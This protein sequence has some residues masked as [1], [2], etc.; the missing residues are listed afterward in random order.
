MLSLRKL[1][2]LSIFATL[3]LSTPISA[4]PPEKPFAV[5]VKA[6][7]VRF[8]AISDELTAVGTL[9]A[10][11]SVIIRPEIAG[12]IATIHFTEGQTVSKGARLFTI[13]PAE[14]E[15]RLADSSAQMKLAQQRHD[16]ALELVKK[17]FI[18]EQALDE[19]NETLAQA[20]AR[21]TQ[22]KVQIAKT[23]LRAP[24]A[25]VLGL[26]QV[27]PGAYVQPGQDL[28]K[29][30]NIGTI[31]L[32]F[33][34]PETYVPKLRKHQPVN[35]EVDAYPKRKFVGEIYAMESGIDVATRTAMLRARIPN[36][37]AEL[38][39]GMFARVII[40]LEKRDHALLIPEQATIPQGNSVSVYRIIDG[41]AILTQVETG[42]RSKG[43]IEIV[44]GL[45]DK[46]IVITD[47]QMKLHNGAPV[48][49]MGAAPIATAP[50]KKP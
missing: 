5:P 4:A 47:G 9:V 23:E 36:P 43:E 16:R 37:N 12:R 8:G 14:Y 45:N 10:N 32:D 24:F 27:S 35:I 49:V 13:E 7:P 26:R 11:E 38:I 34:I 21:Y 2:A 31:K 3:L 17:H 1:I 15:A 39:S 29:L 20:I 41:K 42:Q 28:V 30:G 33:R 46:D 22:D 40:V 44:N 18:S 48:I 50:A 25:G 6:I 19:A